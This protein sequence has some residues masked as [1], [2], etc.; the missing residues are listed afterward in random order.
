MRAE[1]QGGCGVWSWAEQRGQGM[2][3]GGGDMSRRRM[4][5]VAEGGR[6]RGRGWQRVG[7]VRR[8][9]SKGAEKGGGYEYLGIVEG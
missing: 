8:V 7:R 5:G 4:Q 3:A 2:D 9:Q 6:G 1:G